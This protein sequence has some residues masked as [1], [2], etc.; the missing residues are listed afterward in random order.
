M[1]DKIKLF[2]IKLSTIKRKEKAGINSIYKTFEQ[3]MQLQSEILEYTL[4][5]YAKNNDIRKLVTNV[6]SYISTITDKQ[7]QELDRLLD[8][9]KTSILED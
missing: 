3:L 5:E 2:Q 8:I 4:E 9:E 1:M 7:E 6:N